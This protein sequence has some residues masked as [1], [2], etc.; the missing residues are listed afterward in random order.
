MYLKRW[1]EAPIQMKDGT[2]KYPNGKGT[3]QGGVISPLLSNLY[4][5][6]VIDKWM[7]INFPN[8][9]LVRY[10]DDM[11]VHCQTEL[12]AKELLAVCR[13]TLPEG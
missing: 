6:Y 12:Q 2:L 11:I 13:R 7:A 3:P 5:H 9:K 10:A 8:I 1:L 4:L